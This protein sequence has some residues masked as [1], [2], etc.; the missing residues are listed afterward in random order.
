MLLP[1]HLFCV[2]RYIR[3]RAAYAVCEEAVK[4][5]ASWFLLAPAR[6][7]RKLFYRH[8]SR[9]FVSTRVAPHGPSVRK[10]GIAVIIATSYLPLFRI[11]CHSVFAAFPFTLPLRPHPPVCAACLSARTLPAFALL[12]RSAWVGGRGIAEKSAKSGDVLF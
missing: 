2:F 10:R 1:P 7:R 4:P 11:C 3:P 12:R 8:R 9:V 5:P 6:L